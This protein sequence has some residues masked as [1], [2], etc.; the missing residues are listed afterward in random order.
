MSK[1]QETAAL[2]PRFPLLQNIQSLAAATRLY[3]LEEIVALVIDEDE[4]REVLD[5]NF[6][7]G[8]HAKFGILHTFDA[9]DV[10]LREDSC[11]TTD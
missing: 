10:V 9:L 1:E 7:N 4:C 2:Q 5:L 8:L 6:P 11:W 3:L